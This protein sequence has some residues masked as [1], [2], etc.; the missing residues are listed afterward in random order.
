LSSAVD[1]LTTRGPRGLIAMM[2]LRRPMGES[3]FQP[4]N[5]PFA[6][7]GFQGVPE[8][9]EYPRPQ[10]RGFTPLHAP[11]GGTGEA[12]LARDAVTLPNR[13]HPPEANCTSSVIPA[14]AGIQVQ[15]RRAGRERSETRRQRIGYPIGPR[16]ATLRRGHGHVDADITEHVPPMPHATI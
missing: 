8:S 13:R 11:M 6:K 14:E 1:A 4:P 10:Q 15:K 9:G 5:S 12:K 2:G 3:S 16:R 7:G